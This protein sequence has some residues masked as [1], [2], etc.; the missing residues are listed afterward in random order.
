M[1]HK[2]F[3]WF[4]SP[5]VL[6]PCLSYFATLL[7]R[8]DQDLNLLMWLSGLSS[9]RSSL[10]NTELL[11][12]TGCHP[13]TLSCSGP[14]RGSP[15]WCACDAVTLC[16]RVPSPCRAAQGSK[17]FTDLVNVQLLLG[18]NLSEKSKR[19]QILNFRKFY[20]INWYS[21]SYVTEETVNIRLNI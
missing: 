12:G 16:S 14:E 21:I 15:C 7:V 5:A 1:S 8:G 17:A 19:L 20:G 6:V 10:S 18:S 3:V 11:D 9:V 4:N 13:C 2:A